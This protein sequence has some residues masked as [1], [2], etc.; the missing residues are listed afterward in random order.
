MKELRVEEITKIISDRI[1]NFDDPAAIQETGT[2]LTVGDG[3][4]RVYGLESVMAG[5]LVEFQSGVKG[6]V[7]NLELDNVGVAV[8]GYFKRFKKETQ[9]SVLMRSTQFRRRAHVRKSR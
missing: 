7:L 8:L 2:V 6:V 1:K 9:L 5:E 3:I 4:A